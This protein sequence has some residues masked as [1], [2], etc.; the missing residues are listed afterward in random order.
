MNF[1]FNYYHQSLHLLSS[2]QNCSL[3]PVVPSTY[4][5]LSWHAHQVVLHQQSV[6]VVSPVNPHDLLQY[7]RLEDRHELASALFSSV[8]T[9]H[10]MLNE[11]TH[12]TFHLFTLLYFPS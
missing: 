2:W 8:N 5:Y 7:K 12:C 10:Y 9:V 3:P 1:S 6:C 11:C 4:A